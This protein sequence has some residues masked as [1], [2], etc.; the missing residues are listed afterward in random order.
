MTPQAMSH[1][2]S[3][4]LPT[5][6]LIGWNFNLK[7]VRFKI[8]R[9]A[10][11]STCFLDFSAGKHRPRRSD[12]RGYA[13]YASAHMTEILG[14]PDVSGNRCS[15][16]RLTS[17]QPLSLR[18]ALLPSCKPAPVLQRPAGTIIFAAST[19]LEAQKRPRIEKTS[20]KRFFGC[21]E[22]LCFPPFIFPLRCS[23]LT[24]HR[25]FAGGF[26]T[27]YE[28]GK[29]LGQGG[30]GSVYVATHTRTGERSGSKAM[31]PD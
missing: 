20:P 3:R 25:S 13:V 24:D 19:S 30:F 22:L 10:P 21:A 2:R 31:F 28:L 18:G 12:T 1:D 6:S 26:S 5:A 16:G 23:H 9:A 27:E 17:R 29:Q 4:Q 14:R 11:Q 8:S 7:A 15:C